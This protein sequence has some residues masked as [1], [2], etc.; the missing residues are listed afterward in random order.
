MRPKSHQMPLCPC[1]SACKVFIA[2]RIGLVP[3]S[4]SPLYNWCWTFTRTIFG[5]PAVTLQG[6]HDRDNKGSVGGDEPA[7]KLWPWESCRHF[8]FD[9]PTLELPRPISRFMT[10]PAP[11]STASM[12]LWRLW[13]KLTQRPKT[14]GSSQFPFL[15]HLS[16]LFSIP[17]Q[18]S[19]Y[20]VE[21]KWIFISLH[22]RIHRKNYVVKFLKS[23]MGCNDPALQSRKWILNEVLK[24]PERIDN[25][26]AK[27]KQNLGSITCQKNIQMLTFL[28]P[29]I[30][31]MGTMIEHK[32]CVDTL[33]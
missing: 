4:W 17:L 5:H 19:W 1:I 13:R 10:W 33:L 7:L 22:S 14:A 8:P 32:S 6:Q 15:S 20:I 25:I 21:Y 16:S 29:F 18:M 23:Y 24:K 12:I 30:P 3:E 28:A 11:T 9:W 2:K 31:I 26:E 27:N